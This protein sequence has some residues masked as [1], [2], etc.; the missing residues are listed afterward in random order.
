[1]T[2]LLVFFLSIRSLDEP[3]DVDKAET[4]DS[5]ATVVTIQGL[6]P[7]SNYSVSG[8]AVNAAG[9]SVPSEALRIATKQAGENFS[10]SNKIPS[11]VWLHTRPPC[12]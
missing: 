9:E 10:A 5:N 6:S 3:S 2:F 7:Y 8:V 1:M 11:K 4:S 12:V